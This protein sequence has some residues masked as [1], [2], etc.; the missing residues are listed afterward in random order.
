MAVTAVHK[1]Y[2][3]QLRVNRKRDLEDRK[4]IFVHRECAGLF[5]PS[6]AYVS[7]IRVAQ[8]TE[9]MRVSSSSRSKSQRSEKRKL[10]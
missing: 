9:R 1:Y 10:F 8:S 7:S 3:L 6:Y 2:M 5:I 4:L